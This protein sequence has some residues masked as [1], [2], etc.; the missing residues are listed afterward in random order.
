M[1]HLEDMDVE[2]GGRKGERE[3]EGCCLAK[4]EDYKAVKRFIDTPLKCV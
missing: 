2:K 1:D 4:C 3:S